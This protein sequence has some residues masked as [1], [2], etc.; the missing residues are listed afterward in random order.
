M[1]LSFQ[2]RIFTVLAVS[3]AE[4][5]ILAVI[6]WAL[7]ARV[8]APSAGARASLEQVATSARLLVARRVAHEIKN[9]LTSMRIAVEQ[10]QRSL[11]RG[12]EPRI[13]V[14][15]EV[16]SAETDR[17]DRLAREF[18]EFG[19]LPEGPRSEVDLVELLQEQGRTAVPDGVQVTVDANGGRPMLVAHYDPLRRAFANL[20]RNASEAMG[21][22]GRIDIG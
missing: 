9:P 5:T 7:A 20:L 18:A 6:G 13:A 16:L 3:S 21:G 2:Q 10:L 15:A 17:L 1:P 12:A 4:P 22:Q 14:A 19:R 8:G 11:E